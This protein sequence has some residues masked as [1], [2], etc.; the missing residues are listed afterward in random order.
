MRDAKLIYSYTRAQAIE[1]G[2]LVDLTAIALD[3]CREHYKYPIA[4]TS[5]V[6]RLSTGQ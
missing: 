5:A 6:W 4:C 1:D 3:V 2:V